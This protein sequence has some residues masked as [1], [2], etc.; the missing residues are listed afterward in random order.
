[1][2][3][4]KEYDVIIIGGSYAGL[5]A[6]MSLGRSL[7][8]VLIIDSGLPCNRQ[9]PHSHNFITQDGETPAAIAAKA[10][11]QVL[12]YKTVSFINGTAVNAT[13]N[14][15][16]FVVI[17]GDGQQFE[18]KK[19]VLATG[20]KDNM[21][22]VKGFEECWGISVVHCPYCHGYELR[23]RKTAIMAKG[24]KAFHLASLVNNLTNDIT[25][26][27]SG[28]HELKEEQI[29][30]LQRRNIQII[31]TDV[32]AIDHN[33]GYVKSV[34]FADQSRMPF[35]AVYAAVPFTQHSGIPATLGCA[36]T[37]QG[38]ISVD[39]SCRTTVSGVFACGDNSGMM[40]SVANAVYTGNLTGAV[41]NKEF[42]DESF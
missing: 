36:F 31:D 39:A 8:N 26:L 10:R 17:N 16:G 40:R 24:E 25:L 28:K 42:T 23:D 4:S 7:R 38:H 35:D 22:K 6:A 34:V 5:S 41:I 37:E 19:L 3:K 21:P 9:T 33:D 12:A 29:A 15:K 20:I 14:E 32:S 18:S 13:K 2:I 1:M 27:S 30:R 11:E